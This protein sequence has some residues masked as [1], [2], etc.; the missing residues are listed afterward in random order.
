[1]QQN[2][3]QFHLPPSK[4]HAALFIFGDSLFDAGNN[5]YI[6]TTTALQ[7]NFQPYGE[8]FFHHPTGRFSDGRLISDF[9]AEYAK[10]PFPPPYKQP[11]DHQFS[12]GVN[13]ASAGAGA[14]SETNS[15]MVID[16]K[17]QQENFKGVKK[18]LEKNLGEEEAKMFLSRAVYLFSIGG[19]DY[20]TPFLTN[21]TSIFQIYS[22]EEYVGMVIGNLTTA[23]KE[24][25]KLGG[26]KFGFV[27]LGPLGCYPI[28]RALYPGECLEELTTL[29][30]LHNNALLKVLKTLAWRLQ[31]F[32]Y[33]NFD[34]YTSVSERINDPSQ[35]GFK[36]GESACC[37][38]GPY[39]GLNSCGGKRGIEQYEL[40]NKPSQYVFFDF[41]HATEMAHSQLAKIFWAGTPDVVKPVNLK[42][43]F[44]QV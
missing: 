1:M 28:I 15:G 13:F 37:G 22:K 16:L 40:C 32:K 5:N 21:S 30:K 33:S 29:V 19:N 17:M 27:G 26:R 14:L 35:Y 6:N 34:L 39:R 18:M 10:L 20:A 44:E 38:S 42:A 3:S 43:L 4:D 9:I 41:A 12:C 36:E 24:I 23:I 8:T 25:Y 2:S 11:G 7:A 31:G